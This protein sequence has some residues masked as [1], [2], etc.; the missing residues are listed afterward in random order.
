MLKRSTIRRHLP[1]FVDT[2][3]TIVRHTV[4]AQKKFGKMEKRQNVS[5]G[6]CK[7]LKTLQ[8]G[9]IDKRKKPRNKD[10]VPCLAEVQ[11]WPPIPFQEVPPC[12]EA[13][14]IAEGQRFS[15]VPRGAAQEVGLAA[16]EVEPAPV[17]A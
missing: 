11:C 13:P 2:S 9:V 12:A 1:L 16:Q 10:P 7:A 15:V 14:K 4:V 8:E 3:G 5:Q 17:A 6:Y